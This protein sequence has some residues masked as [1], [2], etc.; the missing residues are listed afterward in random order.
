MFAAV[1][2]AARTAYLVNCIDVEAQPQCLISRVRMWGTPP[3]RGGMCVPGV[4]S[5]M[6]L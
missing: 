5:E 2:I 1:E 3:L 6:S 4:A